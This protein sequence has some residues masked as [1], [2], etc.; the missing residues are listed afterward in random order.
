[1]DAFRM[2]HILLGLPVCGDEFA[3]YIPFIFLCSLVLD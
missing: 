2:Q 1:M 3:E